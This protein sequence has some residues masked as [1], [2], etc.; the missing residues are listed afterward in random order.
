MIVWIARDRDGELFMFNQEPRRNEHFFV[1]QKY[2]EEATQWWSLPSD[3]LP[4][5]TWENSPKKYELKMILQSVQ[6]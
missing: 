3:Q 1:A 5:V 6:K 2:K 4:E